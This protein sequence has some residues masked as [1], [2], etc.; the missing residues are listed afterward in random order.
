M[1]Q[2][3]SRRAILTR[4]TTTFAALLVEGD[5]GTAAQMIEEDEKEVR[6][7][8]A[9]F[10]AAWSGHDVKGMAA[11]HTDDVNF[12]NIWGSWAK[13]RTAI[14]QGFAAG[15]STVFSQSKM[16]IDIEQVRFPAA[17]VAVAHS[18][19]ELLDV[20]AAFGGKCHSVR[21]LVKTTGRWLISDFQNTQIRKPPE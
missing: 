2:T 19:M 10:A 15:H 16:V 12:T 3:S 18:T 4:G 7:L 1:T 21:V 5:I 14:E 20:P 13:G 9:S 11:L 17:N 6:E 8:I